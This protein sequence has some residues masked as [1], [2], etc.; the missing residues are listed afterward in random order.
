MSYSSLILSSKIFKFTALAL[1]LSL[2]GCGGG[3]TDT[4]APEPDF[5]NPQPGN[6]GNNGGGNNGGGDPTNPISEVNITPISLKDANGN[7]TR[8]ISASGANAQVKVTDRLG[9]PISS[10][11]VNFS[12]EGVNFGTSNGS[13]LTNEAGEASISL[14]PANSTDTGSYQLKATTN[15]ND[16]S[17][18]TPAYNFSIQSTN[19]ILTNVALSSTNLNSGAS[20]NITLRTKDAVNN[21]FQN[22]I[23]VDFNTSCGT[24]DAT[25]VSS[26]NQGNITAVYTAIDANGN[27]CAGSQTISITPTNTPANRQVVTVN[28]AAVEASSI[29]YTTTE[30]VQLGASGS[31]S[32]SS[33]QIEFTVFANGRPAA[34]QRVEISRSFAPSDFSFVTLNNR[35]PKIV[36]SDS[37]GRVVVNVYPG[38]LP[39]PVEIKAAL[40]SNRN[41]FA[42]SKSVS[43]ATGRAT[44]KGFSL[45]TSKNVL[46]NGVDGDVSTITARLVDRVGNPVPDGT[47]VSFISEGGRVTPNCATIKGICSVEFSTQNPR[48][49]DNRVSIVAFV[50]GDKSYR[51]TNGDNLY[52]ASVDA[53]IENIGD[54]FRDDNENNQYDSNLGEFV[55][56]R[57]A[58]GATC[59]NSSF[60][61]PNIMGT[62]DNEL[63]AILRY[64]LVLGLASDKPV[65]DGLPNTIN[66]ITNRI[67]NFKVFGNS[68]RTI[69][70][71]SGTTVSVNAIGDNC[72]AELVSGNV[73][74]PTDVDLGV[75][76][77]VDSEVSYSFT[78][79]GC[80]SG[81][82]IQ[83]TVA[84][85]APDATTVTRTIFVQ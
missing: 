45:S 48:P 74:V 24:F 57:G 28:I 59:A 23:A 71:A 6:G 69:S 20:T 2:A 65:F 42:L 10:A 25:N 1:A 72:E 44:Q 13:V 34:N 7:M 77:V 4:I 50:E 43:I 27:L 39:G 16:S 68:A 37:Q 58:S 82:R 32:S 66:G 73:T 46:A 85:P 81:D 41:I 31:G 52:T 21:V 14:K 64:Q 15:V 8:T 55:Y 33:G 9:N 38:A 3:G 76:S 26:S 51:D 17:A 19:V 36:T 12:G 83:V 80:V 62:C 35:T 79:T 5:D 67:I 22:D 84:S 29:V 18:T 49:V 78:Q 61:Q 70:M 40:V 60:F 47:V 30:N 53:L 11:L 75:Q 56:R 63:D 54:F